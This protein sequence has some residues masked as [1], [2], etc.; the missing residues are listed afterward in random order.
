[1]VAPVVH[2]FAA[3]TSFDGA[4]ADFPLLQE[5]PAEFWTRELVQLIE[6]AIE[7]NSQLQHAN[8]VS[9]VSRPVP[10]AT[11]ELLAPIRE[12]LSMDVT[13]ETGAVDDDIPF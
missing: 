4:R 11:R 1:M 10:E 3:T 7:D 8:L 9:P 2:R 12:R 13:V 5:I 6:R